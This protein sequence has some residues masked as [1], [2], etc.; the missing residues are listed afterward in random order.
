MGGVRV[1]Y[2]VV[3]GRSKGGVYGGWRGGGVKS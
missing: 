3:D 2:M 1:K